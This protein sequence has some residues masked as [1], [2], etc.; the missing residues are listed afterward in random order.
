[1]LNIIKS[2][3]LIVLMSVFLVFVGSIVGGV[4]LGLIRKPRPQD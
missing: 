2:G 4:I 1:M 3:L